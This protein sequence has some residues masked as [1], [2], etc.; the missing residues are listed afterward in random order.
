MH[1]SRSLHKDFLRSPI[2]CGFVEGGR[3]NI[4]AEP[5]LHSLYGQLAIFLL[6]SG[7][8]NSLFCSF[9]PPLNTA[10]TCQGWGVGQENGEGD[11]E[12]A[13]RCLCQTARGPW[14]H[15]GKC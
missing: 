5:G 1:G 11:A 3:T 15:P 13:R 9:L 12:E 6:T 10:L 2:T 14:A 4:N 7:F 8:L